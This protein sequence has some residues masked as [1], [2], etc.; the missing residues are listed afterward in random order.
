MKA[1]WRPAY[2]LPVALL[3][4]AGAAAAF[5]SAQSGGALRRS[6]RTT[7]FESGHRASFGNHPGYGNYAEVTAGLLAIAAVAVWAH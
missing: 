1:E 5:I 4:V 6:L 2:S 3:A 7:A